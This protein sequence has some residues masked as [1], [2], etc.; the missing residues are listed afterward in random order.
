MWLSQKMTE[1]SREVNW[2]VLSL[3]EKKEFDEAQAVEVSNGVRE[4]AV[5]TLSGQEL[6][7]L[8]W[9][10]V[11]SMRWVRTRK[12]DGRAKA[13]F[14]V[15]G[16][17]AHNVTDVETAAPTLSRTSRNALLTVAANNSFD[18]ESGDITSAFLQSLSNLEDENLLVFAPSELSAM[19]GGDPADPGAVLK[20]TNAFYGLV[21]APRVWHE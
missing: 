3:D 10:K 14:V 5:R 15:L 11:M 17:Q 1:K 19:F 13:R 9:G 7:S 4:A 18:L 21:R 16:Y 8:D 20:L 12:S 6:C 2:R